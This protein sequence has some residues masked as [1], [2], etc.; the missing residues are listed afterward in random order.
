MN[1][2]QIENLLRL[3]P[4]PAPPAGLKDQ[5]IAQLRLPAARPA[6]QTPVATLAPASWLRRWWPVLAP[7]TVSLACAA[8]LTV[9]QMEIRDLKQASQALS[10]DFAAKA[11][12][13]L[14]PTV[15]TNDAASEAD[16]ASRTQQEIARLQELASQL[17]AEVAQLEQMSAENTKLRTQ[18]AAPPAGLFT[19]EETEA[20]AK[21]KERGERIACVNNLKQ[22]GL[23]ARIWAENNGDVYPPDILAMTNEMGTPKILVC[24]GDHGREAAK[25]WAS[26]T[27]ANCSYDYLAPSA[28]I[29]ETSRMMFHCPIHGNWGLCDGSVQGIA[30]D[31]PELLLRRD[32]KIY[33]VEPTQPAQGAPA[34]PSGNPPPGGSNP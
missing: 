23:A 1:I 22:L 5:L 8:A 25:D 21:A 12:A 15:Q 20:L 7:A 2:P 9:Q 28:S 3:A 34:P 19:P 26:Y 14:T 33:L 31:H 6:S 13:L 10:R 30:K 27:S 32:G 4:R 24:P 18:L 16:A 29:T 17:A 11:S